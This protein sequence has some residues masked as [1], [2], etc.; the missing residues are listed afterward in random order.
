MKAEVLPTQSSQAEKDPITNRLLEV[1]LIKQCEVIGTREGGLV[2]CWVPTELIDHEE[3]PV[4]EEWARKL[5]EDMEDEATNGGTGQQVPILLGYVEGE[6]RLKIID[7][8]HRDAALKINGQ[9]RVYCAV[10]S[11]DWDGLFDDRILTAKD[12][13]HVRFSR[14]VKW[15][16]EVWQYSGLDQK[17]G[18]KQ[19][20]L[21][22]KYQLEGKKLDLEPEDVKAARVWVARKE[23]QWGMKALTIYHHLKVA[24]TVNPDLVYSAREKKRGDVLEAPTQQI[25]TAFADLLPNNYELQNL[26]METAKI[27]NLKTPQVKTLCSKVKRCTP[28]E[29]QEVIAE[30]KKKQFVPE[31]GDTKKRQLRQ[32]FDIRHRGG[33]ELDQAE[34]IV[35]NIARR[36]QYTVEKGEPIDDDM[37]ENVSEAIDKI[38]ALLRSLADLAFTLGDAVDRE[39]EISEPAIKARGNG[40]GNGRAKHEKPPLVRDGIRQDIWAYLCGN[41]DI[42]GVHPFTI[43]ELGACFKF[44]GKDR[45]DIPG[46]DTRLKYIQRAKL[47]LI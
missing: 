5:A 39:V 14:V 37:K 33:R 19:A 2:D 32:K 23:K 41:M 38:E 34:W 47:N 3:V 16:H 25:L 22:Y 31:Y 18:I 35:D 40:N 45:S 12:H 13:A 21:L 4:N 15:I 20:I 11:K 30:E 29:A 43:E 28:E 10:Q 36:W 24:E 42:A 46:F 27:H 8:F 17:M 7:G 44:A 1:P 9:E 26:V 6:D